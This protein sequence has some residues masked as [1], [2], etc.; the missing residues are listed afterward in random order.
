MAYIDGTFGEVRKFPG[1]D[2]FDVD[3]I[4]GQ[5]IENVFDQ[6]FGGIFSMP[7]ARCDEEVDIRGGPKMPAGQ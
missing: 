4:A 1:A 5:I 2:F 7:R 6:P 3:D